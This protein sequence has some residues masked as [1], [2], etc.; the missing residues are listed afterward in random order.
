MSTRRVVTKD[1]YQENVSRKEIADRYNEPIVLLD[2]K[3][4]H[5]I[6][7]YPEDYCGFPLF[8]GAKKVNVCIIEGMWEATLDLETGVIKSKHFRGEERYIVAVTPPGTLSMLN[9]L[10]D[11]TEDEL[12]VDD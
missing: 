3:N 1:L 7:R 9:T 11:S 5:W 6:V 12:E 8:E 2:N 4:Y 10:G